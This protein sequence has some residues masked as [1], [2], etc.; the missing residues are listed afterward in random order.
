LPSKVEINATLKN[1]PSVVSQK[2][3]YVRLDV[4]SS[5]KASLPFLI[6]TFMEMPPLVMC[7]RINDSGH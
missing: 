7:E 3:V 1:H 4:C 2:F 6:A 5:K